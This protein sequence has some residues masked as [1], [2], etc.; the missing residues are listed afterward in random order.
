MEFS[1]LNWQLGVL[2]C[3][4][5]GPKSNYNFF[6][7]PWPGIEGSFPKKLK[8]LELG[9]HVLFKSKYWPTLV[10]PP[11]NKSGKREFL[12]VKFASLNYHFA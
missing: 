1:I 5:M 11:T 3:E 12:Y 4:E 8:V 6:K 2:K 7:N 10:L 9:S